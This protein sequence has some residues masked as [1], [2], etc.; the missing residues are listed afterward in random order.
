M[1][2]LK[3]NKRPKHKRFDYIPRFYDPKKEELDKIVDAY[4]DTDDTVGSKERIR[5][6][7]RS[8]YRGDSSYKRSLERSANFR[9]I[10]IILVLFFITY[11]IL[12]SEAIA[13]MMETFLGGN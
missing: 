1:S 12:K 10:S 4:K 3:F 2:F 7:L 9:L 11:L 6:G 8:K 13:R 5:S